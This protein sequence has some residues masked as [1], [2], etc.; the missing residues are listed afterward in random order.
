[1]RIR[2]EFLGVARLVTRAK[3]DF[4]DLHEGATYRELVCHLG[5]RYPA[6]IGDVIQ[7]SGDRLQ[8][9]NI[10]CSKH[11]SIIKPEQMA[12]PLHDGDQ[13]VLMSLSAG[14]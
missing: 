8:G 13:L 12:H 7:P 6:L 9:P 10:F 14:G 4:F 3:E 2:L 5:R 11:T 1:M